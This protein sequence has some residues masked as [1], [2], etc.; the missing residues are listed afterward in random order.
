MTEQVDHDDKT[1]EDSNQMQDH[2]RTQGFDPPFEGENENES[3]DM[4]KNE[5][6]DMTIVQ[7]IKIT[8]DKVQI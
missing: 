8:K 6:D 3:Y 5:L 1:S 7:S 2:L 4:T